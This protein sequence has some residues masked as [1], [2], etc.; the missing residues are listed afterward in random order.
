MVKNVDIAATNGEGKEKRENSE[1]LIAPLPA[2]RATV[3]GA[4]SPTVHT[5]LML[6]LFVAEV[7]VAAEP[8]SHTL[9]EVLHTAEVGKE[10]VDSRCWVLVWWREERDELSET[11]PSLD[12]I[13]H[14]SPRLGARLYGCYVQLSGIKTQ[15]LLC[16]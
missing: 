16:V 7:V 2:S 15:I 1:S 5:E 9:L 3:T 10:V 12:Q 8:L 6:L 4:S 14:S 13:A 11:S